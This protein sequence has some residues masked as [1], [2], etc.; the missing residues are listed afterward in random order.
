MSISITTLLKL[1]V[2]EES[3][4]SIISEHLKESIRLLELP[5]YWFIKE[6]IR[7]QDKSSQNK[8]KVMHELKMRFP[9]LSLKDVKKKVEEIWYTYYD[10][11]YAIRIPNKNGLPEIPVQEHLFY[12]IHGLL[13]EYYG[14]STIPENIENNPKTYSETYYTTPNWHQSTYTSN[15]IINLSLIHI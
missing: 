1:I 11:Q 15:E 6:V 10:M 5:E 7:L 3:L 12:R 2:T 13:A 4:P 9:A 14:L 8:I